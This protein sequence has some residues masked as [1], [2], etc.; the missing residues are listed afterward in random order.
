MKKFQFNL[1]TVEKLRERNEKDALKR[2]AYT[3]RQ[4]Q[5]ELQV[6]NEL[7]HD[8]AHALSRRE[9]L[10][11]LTV[12]SREFLL[13]DLFI[14]GTKSR[15]AQADQRIARAAKEV[16]KAMRGYLLE[17]RKRMMI[18]RLREKRYEEFVKATRKREQ[19][20]NDDLIVMRHRLN[21]DGVENA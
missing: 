7:L 21:F 15:I 6:K 10:A 2:L 19:R 14:Q 1:S 11:G 12:T 3:Q 13:E 16:E 18:T 4:H 8:F 9:A 20:M 17:R 5:A